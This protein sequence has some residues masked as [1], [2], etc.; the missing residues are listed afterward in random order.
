MFLS[1]FTSKSQGS[2]LTFLWMLNPQHSRP[3]ILDRPVL[4][5]NKHNGIH[6]FSMNAFFLIICPYSST[7]PYISLNAGEVKKQSKVLS[8]S[9]VT[10]FSCCFSKVICVL[11]ILMCIYFNIFLVYCVE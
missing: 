11:E 9:A 5:A 10:G 3:A 7:L 4:S 8:Q 1:L 2:I 6:Q